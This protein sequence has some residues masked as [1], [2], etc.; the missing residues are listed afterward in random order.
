MGVRNWL[1]STFL[2]HELGV[3]GGE[4]DRLASAQEQLSIRASA[5][6]ERF[7]RLANRSQMRLAR[8]RKNGDDISPEDRR[9]LDELQQRRPPWGTGGGP[10][11]DESWR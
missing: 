3:V 6:E 4:I 2:D 1:R 9:I 8:S 11:E 10:M 7:Q 5:L